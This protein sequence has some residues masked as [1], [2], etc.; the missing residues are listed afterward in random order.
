MV[1]I[2]VR[3]IAPGTSAIAC[4]TTTLPQPRYTRLHLQR[5]G[6]GDVRETLEETAWE[7]T[8]RGVVGIYRWTVPGNGITYL[9][10]CFHGSCSNHQPQRPLDEGIL[11]AAWLSHGELLKQPERLRSPL[12]LRCI[13]DYLAGCSYPL[14]LLHEVE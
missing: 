8:P 1:N 13:D 9:R 14:E 10:F 2:P 12:V 4:T 7:F 11:R 3:I 6:R 5:S